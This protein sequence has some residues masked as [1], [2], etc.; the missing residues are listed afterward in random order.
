MLV[1]LEVLNVALYEDGYQFKV[2]QVIK[3]NNEARLF[4]DI[5]RELDNQM[6]YRATNKSLWAIITD[7][8]GNEQYRVVRIS[9]G[10]L[11]VKNYGNNYKYLSLSRAELVEVV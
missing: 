2:K 9:N 7:E 8:L 6:K 5:S 4:D 10:L 1:E 11:Q 3:P